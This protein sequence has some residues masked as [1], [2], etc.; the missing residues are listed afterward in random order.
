MK[1]ALRQGCMKPPEATLAAQSRVQATA[2]I[3]SSIGTGNVLY[4]N[5][6]LSSGGSNGG[7]IDDGSQCYFS[8]DGYHVQTFSQHIAAW[9]YSSQQQF[10]N[11]V[12][13]AQ[14]QLLHG[15]FTA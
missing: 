13:T 2:G 6:M 15:D 3:T 4:A 1:V 8:S 12:I 10:S 7:W 11:V 14:A 9:C 5:D